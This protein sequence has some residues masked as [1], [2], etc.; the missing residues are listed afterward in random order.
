MA[1]WTTQELEIAQEMRDAGASSAEIGLRLGRSAA[2]V[3]RA[4][5][6]RGAAPS[7]ND[8]MSQFAGE[9]I[10][11]CP[12]QQHLIED[13]IIGSEMLRVAILKAIVRAA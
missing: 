13:A 8:W 10:E 2:A 7:R 4:L 5:S 12:I 9:A 6:Y 1:N 3:R 11:Q